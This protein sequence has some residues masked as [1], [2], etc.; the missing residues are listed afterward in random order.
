MQGRIDLPPRLAAV[1]EYIPAGEGV[2][3]I[4]TDHAY[5]PIS[6]ISAG[7]CPWAVAA[8]VNRGPLESA[9]KHIEEKG[10][11]EQIR[12]RL[13]NGLDAFEAQELECVVMAG[14]G[15]HLMADLVQ[16]AY[17]TGKLTHYRT[18]VLQPQSEIF[19]VRQAVHQCGSR[20]VQ[21]KMVEDRGK[22]YTIL[23]VQPGQ[24]RYEPEEY[25][26]GRKLFEAR[27]SVFFTMLTE[28]IQKNKHILQG[29]E[30]QELVSE[31][32][33]SRIEAIRQRISREERML[34]QWD[35]Q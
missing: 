7:K 4:G 8:D 21:E 15:G 6:V 22:R 13:S 12:V 29:L 16:R 30:A 35:V 32:I 28:E 10:L 2:V 23:Q 25:E 11:A 24:E 33:K 26:Y 27:D 1:A 14:M 5:L 18:M 3:D 17:E 34:A 9:K 20:I 19:R 31:G